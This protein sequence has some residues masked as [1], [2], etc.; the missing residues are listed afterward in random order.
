MEQS[1]LSLKKHVLSHEMSYEKRSAR[2]KQ[3]KN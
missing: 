1:S 3:Y 2:D